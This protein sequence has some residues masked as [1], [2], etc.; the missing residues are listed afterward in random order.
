MSTA[1]R[2]PEAISSMWEQASAAPREWVEE[3]P[4][5]STIVA[6]GIGLGLG[7]CLGQSLGGSS[8]KRS[9]DM[10]TMEQLGHQVYDAVRRSIPESLS[11][12]LPV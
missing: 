3:Y 10:S 12:H 9:A 2:R 8:R 6:F 4:L 5:T 11:R 7:V 1:Q